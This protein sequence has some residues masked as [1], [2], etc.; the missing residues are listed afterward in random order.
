MTDFAFEYP[1]RVIVDDTDPRITYETGTWNFD[2]L[3]FDTFGVF[4]WPYNET[5][6]GT[7]SRSASFSF[8][9]EG[10]Y[11]QVKGGKGNRN[12]PHP[13]N[14]TDPLN[15][16][17]KYSCEIDG[18]PFA[19]VNYSTFTYFI[20]NLVLCEQ[21]HLAKTRH[22]ISM[23]ISVAD[24]KTQVFWLDS[25]E[26]APLEGASLTNQVLKVDSSDRSCIYH[27]DTGGWESLEGNFGA[28]YNGTQ[29]AGTTMSFKFNGT[30]VS[31]FGVNPSRIN[32]SA[33]EGTTGS[34]NVDTGSAV[35]FDIL[36][37]KGLPFAPGDNIFTAWG[38]QRFFVTDSLDGSNEHE[39][40]ITYSG[41]GIVP[42]DQLQ[43]LVIDY[44]LVENGATQVNYNLS[45][46]TNGST[47]KGK[48][49]R[50]IVGGVVGIVMALI[51]GAGLI[52]FFMK[53]RREKKESNHESLIATPFRDVVKVWTGEQKPGSRN[54]QDGPSTGSTITTSTR[55]PST[56]NA[57]LANFVRMKRAQREAVDTGA[58]RE[59]DSGI[60]YRDMNTSPPP[61]VVGRLPP[62]YTLE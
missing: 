32:N 25:I 57:R 36:A 43:L 1:R 22:T 29:M 31:L 59:E 41:T 60:R 37:S 27:N 48:P 62:A 18:R 55:R 21:A 4:G 51:V 19:S 49:T 13:A 3:S 33:F 28:L 6:K 52:W 46:P 34:Y 12:T 5:M 7:S 54:L 8:T 23:T 35:P 16:L 38:N 45:E 53:K 56:D 10:E 26:Y 61:I 30:S 50:A 20:T 47:I 44:F 2:A 15:L 17:P 24:P 58:V 40:I 42:T 9:F 39:M 14:S 11:V